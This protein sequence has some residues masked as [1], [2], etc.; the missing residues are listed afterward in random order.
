MLRGSVL[1]RPA[2][3]LIRPPRDKVAVL[4]ETALNGGGWKGMPVMSGDEWSSG[5]LLNT[6]ARLMENRYNER[7]SELGL[8]QAGVS[9][10]AALKQHGSSTQA[11]LARR[12][13]L[14]P[15][16]LGATLN[17]M[18]TSGL[19]RR[20]PGRTDKRTIVVSLTDRGA[21]LILQAAGI[22]S[23]LEQELG[24]DTETLRRDLYRVITALTPDR[25]T[26]QDGTREPGTRLRIS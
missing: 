17:R 22:E 8:S 9:V 19:V 7:L 23:R 4:E 14:Q 20:G 6:A 10:L 2:D 25:W 18:E 3:P 5:R 12:L 15:Q 16:T 11:V 13:R 1:R 26:E 24:F 21:K